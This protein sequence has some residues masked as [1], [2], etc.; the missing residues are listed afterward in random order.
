ME[1]TA[2]Y[3]DKDVARRLSLSPSWVR[4]QRNKRAKDQPHIFDLEPCRIGR[5]V[6]Y[7]AADV[8]AFVEAI[9]QQGTRAE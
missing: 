3:S 8:E 5:S 1:P 9:R 7:A 2:F 4:G 6:R